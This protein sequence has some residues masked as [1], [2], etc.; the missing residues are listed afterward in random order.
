MRAGAL[1]PGLAGALHS[2]RAHLLRSALTVL[3]I[4]IGVAAIII[5]MA[6]GAGARAQVVEQLQSLGGNLLLVVPGSAHTLGAKLGSGTRPTLTLADAD[7]VRHELSGALVTAPSVFGRTQVIHGN[8]N[9]TTTV[10][11]ITPDFL[12]AREWALTQGRPI[13]SMDL[14]RA[15]KVALLGA[16]VEGRLFPEGQSPGRVIRIAGLP[17]TV[18]GV[19]DAKGQT[20]TGA[21]QDDKI[22]IP[23]S[24]AMTRVI[25]SGRARV[26]SLDYVMVKMETADQLK[27]AE[28]HLRALLR[29]RHRLAPDRPDDFEI[30]NLAEVQASHEDAAGVLAFWLAAVASVSL[31]VGG[32]SIMNIMLVTVSERTRE[33]GLRMALGARRADI[34][35]Q[36]LIEALVLSLLGA[37]LGI[38]LGIG[39]AQGLGWIKDLPVLIAPAAVLGALGLAASAGVLFG[40]YPALQ[41]ARLEPV[42]ALR[43][44]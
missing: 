13:S 20:T 33:I 24:T 5:V 17:F 29:Q 14:E 8:L 31:V 36:F 34:R 28:A 42:A 43:A 11:G 35:N 25:G 21:D 40:L 6:V 41:A 38:L 4:V 37:G 32:V 39:L 7:A 22:M 3:G 19:L 30:R 26:G 44:E 1:G 27:P 18:I 12:H 9:W 10:Q 15:A 23:L 2:L 16:T